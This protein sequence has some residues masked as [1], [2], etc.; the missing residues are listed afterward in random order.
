MMPTGAAVTAPV[1][2]PNLAA[3]PRPMRR[4]RNVVNQRFLFDPCEGR[5]SVQRFQLHEDDADVIVAAG[6]VGF[7]DQLAARFLWRVGEHHDLLEPLVFDHVAQPV[8]AEQQAGRRLR[9]AV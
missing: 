1:T 6:L 7:L 9:W 4:T 3:E 2:K 8:G 5:Q